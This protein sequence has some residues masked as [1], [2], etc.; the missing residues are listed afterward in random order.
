[1]TPPAPGVN[2]KRLILFIMV[3]VV[4]GQLATASCARRAADHITYRGQDI[5]LTKTYEDFDV[6]KNDP[7]NIDPGEIDRVEKLMLD[8]PMGTRFEDRLQVA[9][10]VV[11]VAFPGYGV[12]GVPEIGQSDGSTV[13]AHSVE[14]P[15]KD[16]ERYFVF[17]TTGNGYE[18]IDDFVLEDSAGEITDIKYRDG[19]ISY[20]NRDGRLVRDKSRPA[21]PPTK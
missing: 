6:Y 19:W 12:S 9:K 21:T 5:K 10:A 15:R 16:K 3:T 17:R 1:M 18:L 8:A 4:A 2:N 7:D 11:D 20:F 13:W 14:I